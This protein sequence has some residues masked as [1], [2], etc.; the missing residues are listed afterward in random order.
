MPVR[1]RA[2]VPS[3]GRDN[4]EFSRVIERITT[5]LEDV[6]SD[7]TVV[8]NVKKR[9]TGSLKEISK[10]QEPLEEKVKEALLTASKIIIEEAERIKASVDES[11]NRMV[12]E[13]GI[14]KPEK[15][16]TRILESEILD[17]KKEI[18]KLER[19]LEPPYAFTYWNLLKRSIAKLD[20]A[21]SLARK[22]KEFEENALSIAE[23]ALREGKITLREAVKL[24]DYYEWETIH[25]YIHPSRMDVEVPARTLLILKKILD[26][27]TKKFTPTRFILTR[28]YVG[29]ISDSAMVA[30]RHGGVASTGDYVIVARSTDEWRGFLNAISEAALTGKVRV[31]VTR[32]GLVV[33]GVPASIDVYEEEKTSL[34][35][36]LE[37][38][39]DLEGLAGSSDYKVNIV[40]ATK[41]FTKIITATTSVDPFSQVVLKDNGNV[42]VNEDIE[43][44]R[45]VTGLE[46]MHSTG[47]FGYIP[48]V[49]PA[50]AIILAKLS[51]AGAGNPII[52]Y[53]LI[54]TRGS[55]GEEEYV[56]APLLIIS[57]HG[58]PNETKI[59]VA[60]GIGGDSA[61]GSVRVT[62]AVKVKK[63]WGIISY[64]EALDVNNND[65]IAFNVNGRIA[66][67]GKTEVLPGVEKTVVYLGVEKS[68]ADKH[69]GPFKLVNSINAVRILTKAGYLPVEEAPSEK[70]VY[71]SE[72]VGMLEILGSLGTIRIA[73]EVRRLASFEILLTS[74][75][76]A[77]NK[78]GDLLVYDRDKHE[79]YP[80]R[81]VKYD[82]IEWFIRGLI[83]MYPSKTATIDVYDI[84][85]RPVFKARMYSPSG[86]EI[87]GY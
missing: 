6:I 63:P 76:F 42:I 35:R 81:N 53:G 71:M 11:I 58:T 17:E 59:M 25:G 41:T 65:I 19:G 52:V 74:I 13:K 38:T 70:A 56:E 33:N 40:K 14:L 62:D 4:S 64:A 31:E 2:P 51:K 18:E 24:L 50:F 72:A 83:E 28:N 27:R 85:G 5:K 49:M 48:V 29:F 87:I 34:A 79:Y 44:H 10:K 46:I 78:D 21:V 30:W 12:E 75:D 61:S 37:D 7:K 20:Y 8:G 77:E 66:L 86:V 32:D 9:I 57:R 16:S 68:W 45:E 15:I 43:I 3:T 84:G 69:A 54:K 60:T 23:K 22:T 55:G 73:G 47:E 1:T 26:G 82:D 67:V 36:L 80:V 39:I